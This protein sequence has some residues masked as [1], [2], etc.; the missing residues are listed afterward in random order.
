MAKLSFKYIPLT[1]ISSQKE[2][3][4]QIRNTIVFSY[5]NNKYN[6]VSEFSEILVST[7]YGLNAA[8]NDSGQHKFLR[9]SDIKEGEVN[10]DSVPFCECKDEKTYKLFKNDILVARTGGT[11]GKSFLIDSPPSN[12]VFAGYLIRLRAKEDINPELIYEFLNSYAYWS[13][14]SE[15]KMGSAQPNV[16]AQKLKKLKIPLAPKGVLEQVN[17]LLSGKQSNLHELENLIEKGMLGYNTNQNVTNL[18][19]EQKDTI[20][21]LRQSILQE[22]VQGKLTQDWRVNNPDAENAS[23]LLKRIQKEKAQLIKDKKI[24]KEK[25]LPKINKEEI[26]YELPEGWVW[27]RLNELTEIITKGSSP[28]WQGVQY[29]EEGEGILFVT[30]ENV[31]NYNLIWKKKKYVE[32]KFN[33]IEPRSI[34]KRN[35]LLMNI[36]G[37]S[38]GRTA[39]YDIDDLANIN[40]AVTIIR[41]IPEVLHQYFLHFFNSP[42]CISYMYDKQVDNARPNLSMGNISK[43]LIP[44]PPLEEQKAIVEK[45]NA[46]MG[47]CDKLEQEVQQSQEHSGQLMQSVLRE[48]FEPNNVN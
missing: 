26:P 27:C 29:V 10:W 23:V 17:I 8:A 1:F 18:L 5:L 48:V 4:R 9:I 44:F 32:S 47:L 36:V 13:Q 2:I 22:A 12:A 35:D 38:I 20:L 15:M 34:L 41:L 30:S 7:Q 6:D 16:N 43:F 37:G 45:V 24:K 46:L 21:K 33:E 31:G 39:I 40:Q 3:Q 19:V 42:L 25:A 14:I 11:T 28:K